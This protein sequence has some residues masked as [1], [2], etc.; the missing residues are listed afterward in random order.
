M[1]GGVVGADVKRD[2]LEGARLEQ[3]PG[4]GGEV[5]QARA[6]GEQQ[7]SVGGERVR[8][9]SAGDADCAEGER[10]GFVDR[11]FAGLRLPRPESH[12]SRQKAASSR[13]GLGVERAAAGDDHA[14]A[15]RP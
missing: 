7:V 15:S 2:D 11:R 9:R 13:R 6:D 5:L 4:A 1:L 8:R 14:A 12:A 3:R 10:V